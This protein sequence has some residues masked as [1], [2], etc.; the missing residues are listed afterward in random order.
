MILLFLNPLGRKKGDEGENSPIASAIRI[1]CQPEEYHLILEL[2]AGQKEFLPLEGYEFRR[3]GCIE[4]LQFDGKWENRTRMWKR[5]DSGSRKNIGTTQSM[6]SMESRELTRGSKQTPSGTNY[7]K[8]V[9]RRGA[10]KEEVK[11]KTE[12]GK[13]EESMESDDGGGGHN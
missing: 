6:E 5:L 12:D 7:E 13:N 2:L 11:R 8:K 4:V 10:K 3:E 1:N 9:R